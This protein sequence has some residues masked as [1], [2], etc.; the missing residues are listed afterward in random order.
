MRVIVAG[1][2]NV[3]RGDDGFGVVVAH[4]LLNAPIPE[5]VEVLDIGIGGIHL[6]QKLLDG[7][8]AL[9]VVDAIDYGRPPGTLLVVRPD[10]RDVAELTLWQRRDEL[11]DMHYTTPD[12][13]FT[14]ARAL[15]V[16]PASTLLVGCQLTDW[17]H[18]GEGLSPEVE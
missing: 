9:I 17:D 11:A 15:G 6:V 8:D 7:A 18:L 13:A 14:L 1:W 2:G 16:L 12:R 4:R 3:L 5:E 10:V